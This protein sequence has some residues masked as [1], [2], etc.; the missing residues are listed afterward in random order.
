M[1]AR[2]TPDTPLSA[3]EAQAI[4]TVA[5]LHHLRAASA[6]GPAAPE[7]VVGWSREALLAGVDRSPQ[8]PTNWGDPTPWR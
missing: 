6:G 5:A 3:E 2:L 4:A 1:I 8:R 7:P